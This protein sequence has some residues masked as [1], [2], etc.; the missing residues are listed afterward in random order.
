MTESS[1]ERIG[2]LGLGIMGSRMAAN[3]ARAGFPLTVWTH[4]PGKAERW[5]AEHGASALRHPGRGGRAQRH[6]REHGRRRRAGRVGAARRARRDR[7][8][9]R[10]SAVRG[11]VDD[12][13]RG[14]APRSAACPARARRRDA[15]RARDRLLPARRGRHADD[16]GRRRGRRLSRA[17]GRCCETMGEPDRP[18]RR[19]RP[20]PDAQAD[21]Q[22]ARRRQ[23]GRAW[24]RRCCWPTP[25]GSTSTR[26]SRSRR[27]GLGRLRAAGS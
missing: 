17:P 23:R 20:G 9:P 15:R 8:G 12:R 4:T 5:A 11:H 1:S 25:P 3:V 26:S 13:A 6:R 27:A 2:F 16:H 21:Q 14:H 19:A 24:R 18:R 7:G 22:L 10:G